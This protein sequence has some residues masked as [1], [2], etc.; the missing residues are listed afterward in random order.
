M[1]D[2][3]TIGRVK[4][5]IQNF[6]CLFDAKDPRLYRAFN[7]SRERKFGRR[8]TDGDEESRKEG[9]KESSGEENRKEEDRKEEVEQPGLVRA[10][11][12]EGEAAR[13]S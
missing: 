8:T 12:S 4:R 11:S 1:E 2:R 3:L 6:F 7:R 5:S 10:A 13:G 9:C